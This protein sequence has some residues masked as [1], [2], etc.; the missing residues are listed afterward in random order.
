MFDQFRSIVMMLAGNPT[1]VNV[2]KM[3]LQQAIFAPVQLFA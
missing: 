1:K 2:R 3:K